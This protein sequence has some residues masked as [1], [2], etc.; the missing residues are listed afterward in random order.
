MHLTDAWSLV[1]RCHHSIVSMFA[2]K[3]KRREGA[4]VVDLM[5]V[6]SQVTVIGREKSKKQK[7][8]KKNLASASIAQRYVE[9]LRLRERIAE[10]ESWRNPR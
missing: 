3:F 6:S 10:V 7:K 2:W 1:L 4:V 5:R 8:A 9:L